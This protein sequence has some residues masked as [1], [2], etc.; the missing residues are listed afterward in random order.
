MA[1]SSWES[2]PGGVRQMESV[3][4]HESNSDWFIFEK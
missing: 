4:E 1:L 3:S 2:D